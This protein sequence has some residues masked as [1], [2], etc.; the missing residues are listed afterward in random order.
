M[1]K[2]IIPLF[3]EEELERIR[4]YRSSSPGIQ[5]VILE[6]VKAVATTGDTEQEKREARKLLK[7]LEGRVD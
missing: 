1:E 7:V 2:K 6:V 5:R 3:T 4:Y